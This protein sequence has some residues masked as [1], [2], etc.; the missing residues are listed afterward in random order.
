MT[1]PDILLLDEPTVGLDPLMEAEFQA[2]AREAA[3]AGQTVFLSSHLLDEVEDVCQ[4]VAILRAGVLVEVATLEEL[5]RLEHDHLR[6]LAE[7][8]RAGARRPARS[9]RRRAD[10]RRG[11][12][13]RQRPA[14]AR[15]SPGSTRPGSGGCTAARPSLEQIFLTY[16][17]TR[18]SQRDAVTAAHGHSGIASR[19]ATV[20]D[21][22]R[23][24]AMTTTRQ[25]G[26]TALTAG[27]DPRPAGRV[28]TPVGLRG[29]R[30]RR[31]GPTCAGRRARAQPGR[32]DAPCTPD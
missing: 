28:G 12:G 15:W 10:G 22:R 8:A 14:R 9:G 7:P 18:P 2:L 4:R 19:P 27:S 11:A 6:G 30:R 16:Y 29:T 32:F 1:R 21:R 24:T 3:A 25:T 26:T 31:A 23:I 5:R 13:H 20:A 17:E